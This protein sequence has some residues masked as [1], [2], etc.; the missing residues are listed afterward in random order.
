MQ[1]PR[2]RKDCGRQN[3]ER[4]HVTSMPDDTVIAL[5]RQNTE[6]RRQL[7]STVA[8]EA[9]TSLHPSRDRRFNRMA[10]HALP[11]DGGG[12]GWGWCRQGG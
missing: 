2:D 8:C 10:E 11:L 6:L 5:E 4:R 3:R 9:T 1:Q 12:P 7:D